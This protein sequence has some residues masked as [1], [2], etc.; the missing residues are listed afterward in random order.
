MNNLLSA[1]GV[2]FKSLCQR[3]NASA[4]ILCVLIAAASQRNQSGMGW[5]SLVYLGPVSLILKITRCLVVIIICLASVF[6][7]TEIVANLAIYSKLIASSYTNALRPTKPLNNAHLVG[8]LF[9]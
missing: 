5:L 8:F 1:A 3:I 4:L 2:V 9:V 6:V 7:A